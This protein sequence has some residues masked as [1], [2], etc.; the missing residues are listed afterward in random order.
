[1]DIRDW[2]AYKQV[3]VARDTLYQMDDA[4]LWEKDIAEDLA[5][6]QIIRRG[7]P[8]EQVVKGVDKVV[9]TVGQE[10]PDNRME[11]R[12]IPTAEQ[13]ASKNRMEDRVIPIVGQQ[14]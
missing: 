3:E 6:E 1:M 5:M 11:H 10:A 8:K 14:V 4:E 2:A 13:E 12:V 7:I 9:P